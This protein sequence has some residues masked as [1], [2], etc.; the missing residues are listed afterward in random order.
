MFEVNFTEHFF[1][2]VDL[3]VENIF[4]YP[5][6]NVY[7]NGSYP[8]E[9]GKKELYNKSDDAAANDGIS[10]CTKKSFKN[11]FEKN[12]ALT[13]TRIRQRITLNFLILFINVITKEPLQNSKI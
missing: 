4:E 9:N 1:F 11:K 13:I 7:K 10:F 3:Y 5:L 2:R 6:C 12:M 8:W